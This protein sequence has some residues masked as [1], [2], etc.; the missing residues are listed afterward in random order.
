MIDVDAGGNEIATDGAL[1]GQGRIV[2][3]GATS[4]EGGHTGMAVARF[5]ATGAVDRTFG[6]DGAVAIEFGADVPAEAV[7]V[8]PDGKIVVAGVRRSGTAPPRITVVRLN[9][10][11]TLDRAFG[12]AGRLFLELAGVEGFGDGGLAVQ[13]DGKIVLAATTL[14]GTAGHQT[15]DLTVVRLNG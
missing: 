4:K 14:R 11:G 5:T 15:D 3:A 7:A 8:A 10:D 1:D 13:Q 12:D 9:E 2:V 6:G